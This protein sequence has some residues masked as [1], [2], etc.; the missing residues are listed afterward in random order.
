VRV[1]PIAYG[2]DADLDVLTTIA[3]ASSSAV[4][5]AKD[6]TSISQALNDVISNF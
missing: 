5:K 1:F 4:Y 6:P 3:Q 2:A